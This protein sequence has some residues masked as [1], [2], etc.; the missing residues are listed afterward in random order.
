MEV[1]LVG[2]ADGVGGWNEANVNPARFSRGL[3]DECVRL[4]KAGN[5][6]RPSEFI[7]AAYEAIIH[8]TSNCYG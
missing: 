4:A 5:V 2:V 1:S 3:M 7:K 6:S 8:P